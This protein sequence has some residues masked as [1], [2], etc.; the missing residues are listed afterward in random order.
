MSS[1][2]LPR[3]FVF[4]GTRR[5]LVVFGALTLLS[6][7]TML[8]ALATMADHGASVLAFESAAGVDRSREILD[9]WGSA[10]KTAMWWQLALDMP[11]LVGYGLFLAGACAAVAHRARETGQPRLER[12]AAVFVWLGPI[13]AASDFTQNVSLALLLS[14]H[15]EQPWPRI[16]ALAAP[17]TTWLG[18]AAA[19]FALAGAVAT[20]RRT[21]QGNPD[22]PGFV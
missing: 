20:R 13:A 22:E 10:G 17:T 1:T 19:V 21:R 16:S 9:E 15:V 3:L 18:A 2:R 12:A 6:G 14:G 5:G 8:P 4:A 7:A 11:F